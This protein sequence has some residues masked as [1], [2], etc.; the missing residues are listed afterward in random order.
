[1][2][3]KLKEVATGKILSLSDGHTFG[4]TEGTTVYPEA[5]KLSRTHCRFIIKNDKVIIKD[6]HSTNGTFVGVVRLDPGEEMILEDQS[7]VSFGGKEFVLMEEVE[8]SLQTPP[9]I[10]KIH[11]RLSS[12][13]PAKARNLKFA[14]RGQS[15]EL[16]KLLFKNTLLTV[17]TLGLYT[18]NAKTNLRKYIWSST[19][20]DHENFQFNGKASD[21]RKAYLKVFLG[22]L[23]YGVVSSAIHSV[24]KGNRVYEL[25]YGF[26]VYTFF[27]LL[28]F[29][30][31][32]GA[33]AYLLNHTSYRSISFNVKRSG[34]NEFVKASVIGAFLNIITL[35]LYTPFLLHKLNMIRINNTH[36]GNIPFRY[37]AQS[38]DYAFLC[39][40][41]L[42]LTIC[43]LGI[44]APWYL[45][46][47]HNF[48]MNHIHL[49]EARLTTDIKG[50][51]LF[52]LMLKSALLIICTFGLAMPSVT[53]MNLAFY[54][55]QLSFEGKLDFD[56]IFQGSKD[57]AGAFSDSV[58]DVFD[59][60]VA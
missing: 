31:R 53:T 46:S 44:Y 48:K 40:K 28:F 33:F 39:F 55:N 15:F 35:G 14:Y 16:F 6:L 11:S 20:L 37:E 19:V 4:R 2:Q 43:T 22:V 52:F 59:L 50:G 29:K 23:I 56:S 17:L 10:Q 12:P 26:S 58:A 42:L 45:A 38:K 8:N 54:A 13:A 47:L 60:E 27:A 51:D 41:G 21:L 49:K 24:I 18:P 5:K 32:Y 1:M 3:W 25:T 7:S 57:K 36:F 34:S 9:P 30:A